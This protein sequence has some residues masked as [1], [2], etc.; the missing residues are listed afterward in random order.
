MKH[1]AACLAALALVLCLSGVCSAHRVN[2][3]AF[4]D[5]GEIQ[6]ECGF[7]KSQKVKGGKLV[8]TDRETGGTLLE[9]ITD[10]RGIFRF[11]PEDEFLRTGHGLEIL[12]LAGEGHRDTW[13]VSPEELR[14]LSALP[15]PA[16]LKHADTVVRGQ[17][18]GPPERQVA[19]DST[20]DRSTTIPAL[21]ANELEIIVGKVVDAKLAPVKQALARQQDPGLRDIVGGIGWILGLL[22]LATYMKYRRGERSR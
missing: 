11:R 1:G 18:A 19:R 12:L 10:D 7:S 6:V 14:A 4:V 8:I 16:L 15:P 17:E 21:D 22:G 20:G 9:G 13:Q 2:V 5:G 3:F